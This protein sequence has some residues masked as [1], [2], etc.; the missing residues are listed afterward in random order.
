MSYFKIYVVFECDNGNDG[1]Y[2]TG[3]FVHVMSDNILN[4]IKTVLNDPKYNAFG[5]ATVMKAEK[6]F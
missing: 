6:E 2:K 1:T 3:L 5:P 4:A